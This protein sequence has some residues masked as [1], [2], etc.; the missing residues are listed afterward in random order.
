[1]DLQFKYSELCR[2]LHN[3]EKSRFRSLSPPLYSFFCTK[4]VLLS[5]YLPLLKRQG[6]HTLCRQI[7]VSIEEIFEDSFYFFVM[8][9]SPFITHRYFVNERN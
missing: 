5:W 7:C 3:I 2:N 8:V 1:M 6:E 9:S 4:N